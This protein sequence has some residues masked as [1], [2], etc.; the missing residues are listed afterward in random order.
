MKTPR[1]IATGVVAALALGAAACG[2]GEDAGAKTADGKPVTIGLAVAN[3]QAD[4]FNQIKQSVEAEAKKKGVKVIVSDARGDA[5]TQVNQI[6]DFISRQ[7]SAIIY[8]PAGATAA[9]V[10]VK[11]ANRAHIPV[12]T[13]D[14]NPPDVPGESFIATDSVAAAKTLGEWVSKQKGGKGQLAILQGQIGTTP[15]VDRQKG[16]GQALA[17]SPGIKVVSQQSA[18][19]AQDK[20]Y[21]VAQDMLQAHPGI[22]IMWGQA[23]AMALGAAQAAK[24]AGGKKRLIVG[25]D[26]DF[27]GI[28]AVRKGTID[29]TMVQQTQ[30]M[31][32]M[33]VDTALDILNKKKV[34]AMQLQPAYLL[35]KDDTAKA[36]QYLKSHP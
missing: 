21:S 23:D 19:W 36:D 15:Q 34:P 24:G 3:L 32:R 8:I 35:T 26:G 14:R 30:K 9:G 13:V 25:F 18:D 11:A 20:A 2:R 17:E 31:G 6:Q 5:A 12:V 22:D 4:F 10:P 33:A 27:A 29:A 28:K 7:V 1:V 16:F